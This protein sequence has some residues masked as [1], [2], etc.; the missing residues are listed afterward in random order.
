MSPRKHVDELW[1]LVEVPRLEN[2][3]TRPRQVFGI[4]LEQACMRLSVALEVECFEPERTKLEQIELAATSDASFPIEQR[5]TVTT[6][7][8]P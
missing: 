5:P 8:S 4:R 1:Q 6:C 2:A 7:E 3:S